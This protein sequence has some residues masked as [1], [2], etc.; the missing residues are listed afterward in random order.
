MNPDIRGPEDIPE[1][2]RV[3]NIF[4]SVKAA[5][6]K[7]ETGYQL[8]TGEMLSETVIFEKQMVRSKSSA[9]DEKRGS[10]LSY[11]DFWSKSWS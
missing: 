11:Q 7:I 5:E 1:E 6:G 8:T 3:R 10:G 4:I 9:V 2:R